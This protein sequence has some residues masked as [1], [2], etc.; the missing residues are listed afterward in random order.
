MPRIVNGQIYPFEGS[1]LGLELSDGVLRHPD[2]VRRMTK[3]S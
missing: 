3:A 2:V 1:G